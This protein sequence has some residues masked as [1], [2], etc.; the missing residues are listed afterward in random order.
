MKK[1]LV[2]TIV[3]L[4]TL[5]LLYSYEVNSDE[6]KIIHTNNTYKATQSLMGSR[7]EIIV[8]HKEK[9][10]AHKS[11]ASA[12]QKINEIEK[13]ISS[14]DPNSITSKINKMS[15]IEPVKVDKE[16]LNFIGRCKKIS[17]LTNGIFDISFASVDKHWS[18]KTSMTKLPNVDE[19]KK[20]VRLINF[21]NIIINQKNTTIFLKEK[22]MKIGF[23]A[24]GKGYAAN[25]AK[26]VLVSMGIKS[27]IVNAG[28]DLIAWGLQ[29]NGKPWKIKIAHPDNP[30]KAITWLGISD[31]AIVTSGNYE[32]YVT[33]NGKQ[34]CHIINPKTGYPVSGIKSVTIISPDT[35]LADAIATSVFILGK[36][37]GMKLIN[38]LNHVEGFI[39][40]DQLTILKSKNMKIN[41]KEIKQ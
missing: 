10:I 28:G 9:S 29:E 27:G 4:S 40:D 3:L 2:K 34:Y 13:N 8:V 7:F 35:E 31:T 38:K 19:L 17:S 6:I 20:S 25:H 16:Y 14:W 37:K 41:D 5:L 26:K 1:S 22:G 39:I 24:I 32:H 15:G 18:F 12:F 11:I 23:G 36:E 21:K 30:D 33:I